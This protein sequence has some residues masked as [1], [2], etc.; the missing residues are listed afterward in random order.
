MV[1]YF[2]RLDG[3]VLGDG[4]VAAVGV[5]DLLEVVPVDGGEEVALAAEEEEV[6]IGGGGR[7]F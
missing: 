6:I 4:E 1:A 5:A 3:E 7:V 2:I